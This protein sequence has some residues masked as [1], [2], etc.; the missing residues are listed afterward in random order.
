MGSM[1]KDVGSLA[2]VGVYRRAVHASLERVWENVFDWEHL[3]HLHHQSFSA[4]ECVDSGDWGWRARIALQP[5]RAGD[6][7]ELG[8]AAAV[9]DVRHQ[10]IDNPVGEERP[11]SFHRKD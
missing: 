3:P 2:L 9:F 11:E 7:H 8:D 10:D 6:V 5:R 4:I 1:E